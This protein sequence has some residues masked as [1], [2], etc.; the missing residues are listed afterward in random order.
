MLLFS[1]LHY[2]L[3]LLVLGQ[4]QEAGFDCA[5]LAE[6]RLALECTDDNAKRLVYA[7]PQRAEK[8]L[9]VALALGVEALTFDGSEELHKVYRAHQKHPDKT[10][11]EMILRIL[12]P[13]ATSSVPLG[14]KFGAPPERIEG[15]VN[16]AVELGL[17]I[18]GVSFHCGSGCHDP[19]A[20][21][22]AIRLAKNAMEIVDRVQSHL[23]IQC[24]LLDIGGGYP[25]FDGSEGEY[26]RF[27]GED[28][29]NCS[30][31]AVPEEETAAKIASAVMPLVDKL[32]PKTKSNVQ[33][34]SEPGRYFVEAAY[35][36]CSRIYSVRVDRDEN[37][38][39]VHRHYYIAQGVQGVFKD[40]VLCGEEFLPIPLKMNQS[41]QEDEIV[42][43]STVHGPTSEEFDIVCKALPLPKL[44]VGDWLIFDRMGA[45]TLSIAARSGR[46]PIRHVIGGLHG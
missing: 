12:V 17:P 23:G 30:V 6:I 38:I 27:G 15:L 10:A 34:I 31:D 19:E 46:L 11:P 20:Y 37:D 22:T 14:E 35:A 42:C 44:E 7:N 32:F 24:R 25:G 1:D 4:Y 13:D 41:Q 18:V 40:V 29:L 3:S 45:Y 33:I 39:E 21:C 43:V 28:S 2:V 26:E 8:D 16:E 36:V 9:D 5:S